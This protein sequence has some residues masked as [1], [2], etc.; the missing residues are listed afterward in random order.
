MDGTC[1]ICG[2]LMHR[3]HT[4]E[5]RIDGRIKHLL[6]VCIRHKDRLE[7]VIDDAISDEQPVRRVA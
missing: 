1:R 2:V 4:V 7:D 6:D 3:R 5:I